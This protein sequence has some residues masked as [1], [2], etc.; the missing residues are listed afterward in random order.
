MCMY[1]GLHW[2]Q[3]VERAG[4]QVNRGA[5]VGWVIG[6]SH[7]R[8]RRRRRR[9]RRRRCCR[10]SHGR[11]GN[12]SLNLAR[13]ISFLFLSCLVF[14]AAKLSRVILLPGR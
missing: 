4:I 6:R 2:I 14:F 1:W 5:S 7:P 10:L 13:S 12:R 8:R 11:L 9:W 3:G